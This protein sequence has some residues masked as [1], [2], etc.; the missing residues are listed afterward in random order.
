M[1]PQLPANSTPSPEPIACR[2]QAI[3]VGQLTQAYRTYMIMLDRM[4]LLSRLSRRSPNIWNRSVVL[5]RL[6]NSPTMATSQLEGSHATRRV[7]RSLYPVPKVSYYLLVNC[8]GIQY[9]RLRAEPAVQ[10]AEECKDDPSKADSV[11]K[12]AAEYRIDYME[13]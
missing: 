7:S 6:W 2:L 9:L 5:K 4:I 1:S 11:S 10:R 13:S 3:K 8:L 12:L